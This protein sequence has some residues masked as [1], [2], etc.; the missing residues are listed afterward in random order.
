MERKYI[1]YKIGNLLEMFSDTQILRVERAGAC[2]P[3]AKSPLARSTRS[4]AAFGWFRQIP[5][6]LNFSFFSLF[7][8]NVSMKHFFHFIPVEQFF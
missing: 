4:W 1:E 2:G 7:S 8:P 3:A 5:S 6:G